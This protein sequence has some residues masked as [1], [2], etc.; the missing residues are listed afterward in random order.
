MATAQRDYYEV[1]GIPR[2]ADQKTIKDAFRQ[3]T[4]KYHPDRNKSAGA[5]DK[6]KEI[7][8]AY[9]ILSDPKK[10]SQYDS[11]GFSGV[12]DF[13]AED[14]FGGIDFG[15]IFSDMGFG[16]NFGGGSIFDRF[17]QQRARRPEKGRD[18]EVQLRVSLDAI[19]TGSEESIRLAHPVSCETCNGSG[20]EPGTAPRT[21]DACG[22]S[23]QK[24]ISKKQ[25]NDNSS[26]MYQQI[27]SCPQCHGQG[28]IIDAPCKQ[29][30][31]SGQVN[32]KE[33][34]KV[35]V[36]KGAAEGM[37]LRIPGH[38]MPAPSA[39]AIAGDLYVIVR[40]EYDERFQRSGADLWRTESIHL[41]DAVLGTELNVPTLGKSIKVKVPAGTQHDEILRLKGKGLPVH[42]NHGYG[43]LKIRIQVP[44]P[45]KISKDE[46]KLYEQLR[47]F[48]KDKKQHWWNK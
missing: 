8:E 47:Q 17:R 15:D 24:V 11:A 44:I 33:S 27:I 28:V 1:L 9:A 39:N 6:F 38:G 14:L 16:F 10:R 23:G 35:K 5:E 32:K 29:C 41:A 20:A 2:D 19:N 12:A 22:G 34:L 3:L 13:S 4:L 46:Q 45:D 37:A 36:P 48:N 43:D 30:D 7:A 25:T 40:T 21:C 26:V 42:D 31:G 18:I